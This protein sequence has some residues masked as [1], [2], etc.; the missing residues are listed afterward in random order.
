MGT[1]LSHHDNGSSPRPTPTLP[2]AQLH[3]EHQATIYFFLLYFVP[4]HPHP[5][6][7]L[8]NKTNLVTYAAAY[9]LPRYLRT[10]STINLSPSQW[11]IRMK[12]RSESH[13]QSQ[14]KHK[15]SKAK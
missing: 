10:D 9:R 1:K 13:A 4:P 11:E 7:P 6:F 12:T 2:P 14:A 3:A 15:E 5:L 8:S